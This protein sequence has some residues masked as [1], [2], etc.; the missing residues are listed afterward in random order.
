MGDLLKGIFEGDSSA[1]LSGIKKIFIDLKIQSF[2]IDL[3]KEYQM[4]AMMHLDAIGSSNKE[5]DQTF[6]LG[7]DKY[8]TQYSS[9]L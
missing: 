3:M 4:R 8:N 1:F 7:I 5:N 2:I 9:I 6:F